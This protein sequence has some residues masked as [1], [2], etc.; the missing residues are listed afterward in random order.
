MARKARKKGARTPQQKKFKRVAK[1]ANVV[2]HRDT[3]TV[4]G[5]KKCMSTEMKAGLGKRKGRKK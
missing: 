4:A 2:C 1:A 5:Y 3:N